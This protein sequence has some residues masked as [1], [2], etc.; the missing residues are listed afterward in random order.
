MEISV[1]KL[2]EGFGKAEEVLLKD[3]ERWSRSQKIVA[4]LVCLLGGAAF[5]SGVSQVR[6]FAGVFL[7]LSGVAFLT[8]TLRLEVKTLVLKDDKGNARIVLSGEKGMFFLDDKANVRMMAK[9]YEGQPAILMQGDKET[10]LA[11]V[12]APGALIALGKS[13]ESGTALSSRTF[14]KSG[15]LQL[16]SL[17]ETHMALAAEDNNAN[18]VIARQGQKPSAAIGVSDK[19]SSLSVGEGANLTATASS[20]GSLGLVFVNEHGEPTT[21]LGSSDYSG[22]LSFYGEKKLTIAEYPD[23]ESLRKYAEALVTGEPSSAA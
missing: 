11:T 7:A 4:F 22:H 18:M 15:F 19:S 21:I 16:G 2:L 5:V 10:L 12:V 13:E 14:I 9:V 23:R 3:S 20:A 1:D 6:V 8:Y 17:N